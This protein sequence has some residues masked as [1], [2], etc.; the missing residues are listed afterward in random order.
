MLNEN[1]P[2]S[3]LRIFHE[4]AN[5]WEKYFTNYFSEATKLNLASKIEEDRDSITFQ[6]RVESYG[7]KIYFDKKAF[8]GNCL[9]RAVAHQL[10]FLYNEIHPYEEF[11]Q[12]MFDEI[13]RICFMKDKFLFFSKI[14]FFFFISKFLLVI[15]NKIIN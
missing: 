6:S 4:Y 10:Y 2:L 9:F 14:N 15:V 5:K 12:K 7:F 8:D 3:S 1:S 13:L 11:R